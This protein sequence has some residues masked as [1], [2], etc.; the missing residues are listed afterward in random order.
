MLRL[1]LLLRLILLRLVL[2]RLVL[3]LA[4]I[5]WLRLARREGFSGH[6]RL[7]AVAVIVIVIGSIAAHVARLLLEI[8]LR[9]TKLFLG[10]GDQ[11]E[12]ML[13]VLIIIFRCDRVAGTLR[14]AREL[15]IFFRDM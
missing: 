3:L 14:V 4:R 8:R 13:G 5:E 11:A 12:V 10:G 15:K 9:L 7:V 2:L 1:R 6:G